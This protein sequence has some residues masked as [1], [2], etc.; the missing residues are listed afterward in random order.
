MAVIFH[1]S[2]EIWMLELQQGQR[3]KSIRAP[4]STIVI[5]HKT[6]PMNYLG[7][8]KNRCKT[9]LYWLQIEVILPYKSDKN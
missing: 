1:A 4:V 6:T 3:G 2:T 5:L 8:Y 9:Y 7:W